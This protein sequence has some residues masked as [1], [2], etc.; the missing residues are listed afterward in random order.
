MSEAPTTDQERILVL[1]KLGK[2]RHMQA[3]LREGHVYMSPLSHFSES[4]DRTAHL[5]PDEGLGLYFAAASTI[6]I[7]DAGEWHRVGTATTPVS[8]RHRLIEAVNIYSLFAIGTRDIGRILELN[9]LDLGEAF[10]ALVNPLEFL[11]RLCGAI[12]DAG[13][14]PWHGAVRYVDRSRH[15]G[16]MGPARKFA[17]GGTIR[18]EEQSEYRIAALPGLGKPLELRLGDL[19]DIG[20]MAATSMRLRIDGPPAENVSEGA[21]LW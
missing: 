18:Y 15:A 6:D 17:E 3:L 19:S 7:E 9:H 14:T 20:F 2:E 8:V 1:V 5:D 4:G 12:V 13:Q 16:V 21:D 10:V 11:R